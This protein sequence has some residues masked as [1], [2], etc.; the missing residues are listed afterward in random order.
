LQEYEG[1]MSFDANEVVA[2]WQPSH[3]SWDDWHRVWTQKLGGCG[4]SAHAGGT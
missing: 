1:R 4:S 3:G 2:L